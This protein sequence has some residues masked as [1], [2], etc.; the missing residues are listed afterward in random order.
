MSAE[1][2]EAP[3]VGRPSAEPSEE[4]G[5]GRPSPEEPEAGRPGGGRRNAWTAAALAVVLPVAVGLPLW[6][7]LRYYDRH[8]YHEAVTTVPAGGGAVLN[9]A[10]WRLLDLRRTSTGVRMRFRMTP[11]DKDG[12]STLEDLFEVRDERGR[13]WQ[14]DRDPLLDMVEVGRPVTVSVGGPVPADVADRVFPVVRY[15]PLKQAP[16]PVPVLRFRR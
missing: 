6:Q 1:P 9:H 7:Q 4:P 13:R 8:R 12:T 3:E 16:G 14:F 10:S 15:A 11:L 2:S 5:A